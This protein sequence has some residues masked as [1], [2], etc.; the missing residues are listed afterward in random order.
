MSIEENNENIND[1]DNNEVVEETNDNVE[2]TNE[3]A[4]TNE[5]SNDEDVKDWKAEVEKWRS[6]SRKNEAASKENYKKLNELTSEFETLKGQLEEANKF[7]DENFNLMKRLVIAETGLPAELGNRLNGSNEE[8]L[9]QDAESLKE[10]FGVVKK[11]P[12][13]V[14]TQGTDL[15]AGNSKPVFKSQEEYT[16]YYKNK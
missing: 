9:K 2:D 12:K 14:R 6:N 16:Q 13:P 3:N 15:P 1:N 5:S 10:L 7:K 11:T 4:S 8:E